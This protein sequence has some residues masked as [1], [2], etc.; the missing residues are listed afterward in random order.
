MN[1]NS[2]DYA[3]ELEQKGK[4]N[5]SIS[6]LKRLVKSLKPVPKANALIMLGKVYK[7]KGEFDLS[8]KEFKEA[9][10]ILVKQGLHGKANECKLQ[11]A[12]N[13]QYLGKY[14]C[15]ESIL[16]NLREFAL[17]SSDNYLLSHC[18]MQLGILHRIQYKY[19]TAIKELKMCETI[20]KKINEIRDLAAT[21][22]QIGIVHERLHH[23]DIAESMYKKSLELKKKI[24]YLRGIGT[25]YLRMGV[26][27]RLLHK[28]SEARS[29][30]SRS[31]GYRVVGDKI[32]IGSSLY[33]LAKIEQDSGNNY[34]AEYL[35]FQSLAI[36]E[37]IKD[38]RR[39]GNACFL[40][41]KLL[42]RNNKSEFKSYLGRAE[43]L[44]R[45]VKQPIELIETLRFRLSSSVDNG[46]NT[47]RIK[48]QIGILYNSLDAEQK[49]YYKI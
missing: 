39:L 12:I 10:L 21:I 30:V 22:E 4:W 47:S 2:I 25:Y 36:R 48:T 8:I 35:A 16:H 44:R 45:Y 41:S 32:G 40:L 14:D 24:C 18:Y 17:Q 3:K 46:C 43:S 42:F 11:E 15:C 20:K 1:H 6:L 33:E 26:L 28:Y 9:R 19:S 38:K 31:L 37:K 5:E 27:Y 29:F 7:Y 34:L 23:Y 49:K 13:L